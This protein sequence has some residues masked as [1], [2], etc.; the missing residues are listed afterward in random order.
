MEK[1]LSA[2]PLPKSHSGE[3]LESGSPTEEFFFNF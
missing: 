1:K 2:V 3:K